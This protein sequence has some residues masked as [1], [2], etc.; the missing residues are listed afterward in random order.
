MVQAQ[1][2]ELVDAPNETL[3]VE[4]K[5]WLDLGGN[6]V[7]RANFARHIAALCNFGG[8][9]IVVGFRD[10]PLVPAGPDPYEIQYD[11][12][13]ISSITKRYL[14]PPVQCDIVVVESVSGLRHPVI[15]V[16]PHGAVPICAKAGGPDANGRPQGIVAGVHY[17]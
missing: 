10:H 2:S 5:E 9:Y 13:L 15:V 17:T 14:A 16:P 7:A 8:G 12:D 1:L 11:R 4:Y 3:S 6:N